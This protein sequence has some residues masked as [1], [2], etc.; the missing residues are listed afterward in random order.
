MAS[1]EI[2]A[3]AAAF[4]LAAACSARVFDVREY[5]AK[6]DGVAKDTAAI[7]SAIDDAM[8]ALVENANLRLTMVQLLN[9]LTA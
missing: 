2:V 4:C 8:G 1:R 5:G 3:A 7:Q 6:G 9:R